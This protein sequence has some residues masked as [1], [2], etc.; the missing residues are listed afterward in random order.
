MSLD[1]K[2]VSKIKRKNKIWGRIRKGLA[3]EEESL[4]YKRIRNQVRKLTRKAKILLERNV[5][6][7]AKSNPKHFWRYTQ[8]KLKTRAGI[9][10]L[11][12][13][14]TG[15]GNTSDKQNFTQNDKEKANVF[16]D[17]FSS[18]FTEEQ[19]NDELPHFVTRNFESELNLIDI[20]EKVVL[21]KTK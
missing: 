7:N 8:S 3:S 11:V 18:V 4:N 21:K 6:K 15:D 19:E 13:P 17:Y 12:K 5:A 10:D 1:R 20:D 2:T 16:V 14:N 9:P